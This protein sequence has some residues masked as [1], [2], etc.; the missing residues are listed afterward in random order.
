MSLTFS[1]PID[2]ICRSFYNPLSSSSS[3]TKASPQADTMSDRSSLG[4]NSGGRSDLSKYDLSGPRRMSISGM[5]EK[6]TTDPLSEPRAIQTASSSMNQ[7]SARLAA[8]FSALSNEMTRV[9]DDRHSPLGSSNPAT[10]S[11]SQTEHRRPILEP[12]MPQEPPNSGSDRSDG[13]DISQKLVKF[14]HSPRV[15]QDT[16]KR[17]AVPLTRELLG[18]VS[19]MQSSYSRPRVDNVVAESEP[20]SPEHEF[21]PVTTSW[22][23]TMSP[24]DVRALYPQPSGHTFWFVMS[25]DGLKPMW[26]DENAVGPQPSDYSKLW[27]VMTTKG[28]RTMWVDERNLH[29]RPSSGHDLWFVETGNGLKSF[30][31]VEVQSASREADNRRQRN[32]DASGRWRQRRLN[33]VQ[34]QGEEIKEVRTAYETLQRKLDL[35]K[36]ENAELRLRL[37]GRP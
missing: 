35:L 32:S 6:R 18:P 33:K 1:T 19:A 21:R 24:I 22:G 28:A 30:A 29:P 34:K 14:S 12:R 3:C 13:S 15:N 5:I 26:V 36:E 16:L 7:E 27:S 25:S 20:S 9:Q 23:P 11:S 2:C 31:W 8:P 17:T 4:G 37:R 10:G